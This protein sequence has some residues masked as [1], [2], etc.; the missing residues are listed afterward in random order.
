[1]RSNGTRE[2]TVL[3]DNVGTKSKGSRAIKFRMSKFFYCRKF[4]SYENFPLYGTSMLESTRK[5]EYILECTL[6][7]VLLF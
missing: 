7:P 6:L 3:R 2:V 4:A 5:R 1:M